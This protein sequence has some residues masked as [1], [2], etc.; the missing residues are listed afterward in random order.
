M[1]H[2]EKKGFEYSGEGKPSVGDTNRNT[3][4]ASDKS[5]GSDWKQQVPVNEENKITPKSLPEDYVDEAER[6]MQKLRD[7][8]NKIRFSITT[9][10]IRAILSLINDIY[11]VESISNSPE[12]N[13]KSLHKI[14]R[15]RVKI[16]Y[17]AGRDEDAVK[18]FVI[19]S[20]ILS[21][22]L[23]IGN[24]RL[25]FMNF[26]HYVEALVAYHRYLGGKD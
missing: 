11:N 24:S 10:K 19:K 15:M 13:E 14:Q 5:Q 16:I 22:L 7:D 25:K 6:V 18:P 12:L 21:Y 2:I 20:N 17:D 23:D 8:P 9:S 26:A 3:I 1:M 4:R